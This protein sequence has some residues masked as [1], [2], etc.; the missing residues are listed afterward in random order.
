V[1]EGRVN[2]VRGRALYNSAE[3]RSVN[4]EILARGRGK[5]LAIDAEKMFA[6]ELEEERLRA[7]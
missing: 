4:G 5:F 7:R 2:R 3:I 6:R 1:A